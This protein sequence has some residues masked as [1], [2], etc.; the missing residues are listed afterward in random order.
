MIGPA[1]RRHNDRV[2]A[3]LAPEGS[4]R[5]VPQLFHNVTVACDEAIALLVAAD[6]DGRAL[7]EAGFTAIADAIDR[8]PTIYRHLVPR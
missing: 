4:M 2:T 8:R 6:V 3:R 7:R 1:E 5:A